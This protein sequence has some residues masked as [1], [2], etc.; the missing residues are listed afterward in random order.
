[1]KTKAKAGVEVGFSSRG[2]GSA[3]VKKL[4]N[5]CP[6]YDE[7]LNWQDKEIE[8]VNEDYRLLSF[9]HVVGQ[10]VSDAAMISYNENKS[11]VDRMEKLDVTK[12]TDE[13]W[14]QIFSSD[15]MTAKIAESVDA[16]AKQLGD[17]SDSKI[18]ESTL[19]Y[20]G[21]EKFLEDHFESEEE[22]DVE[23]K[24]E[25]TKPVEPV[26]EEAATKCASCGAAMPVGAKFCPACGAAAAKAKKESIDEKEYDLIKKENDELKGHIEVLEKNAMDQVEAIKISEIL[27]ES[28]SGKSASVVEAVRNDLKVINVTSENAKEIVE[29]RIE[30]Y[31]NF[32]KLTGGTLEESIS[33]A[34]KH[35]KDRDGKD[36]ADVAKSDVVADAFDKLQ[37]S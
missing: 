37:Q 33:T 21:S 12:L 20:L 14:E 11:E 36:V 9:D 8:F 31:T 32:A 3:N 6:E 4:T 35:S 18:A 25:G 5:E 23:K 19:D 13:Q 28:F 15:K 29:G 17:E 30:H 10:A 1:M 34:L 16:K 27:E 2:P 22:M 7:N 26:I 24:E